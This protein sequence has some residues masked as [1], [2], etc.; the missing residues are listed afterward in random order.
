MFQIH[1]TLLK[2]NLNPYRFPSF[3]KLG[4][5]ISYNSHIDKLKVRLIFSGL[6]HGSVR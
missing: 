3:K 5:G 1:H 6:S 2:L 4:F